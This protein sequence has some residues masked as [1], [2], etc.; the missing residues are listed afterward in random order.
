[1]GLVRLGSLQII[2]IYGIFPLPRVR[3]SLN[4]LCRGLILRG[5]DT[6]NT[7]DLYL[8]LG[9][10]GRDTHLLQVVELWLNPLMTTPAAQ[11]PSLN[12]SVM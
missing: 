1:V 7:Q 12:T 4:C 10:Q 6:N 11:T 9:R 5:A 3:D 8:E 2:P